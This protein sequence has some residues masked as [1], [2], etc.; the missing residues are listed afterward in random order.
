MKSIKLDVWKSCIKFTKSYASGFQKLKF[1]GSRKRQWTKRGW[2]SLFHTQEQILWFQQILI[3]RS[4][5][6]RCSM[7]KG[8]L[9]NF[10]KFT[11][12]HLCRAS[13]LIRRLWHRC[14]SVNFLNIF[15]RTPFVIEPLWW[16]LLK[17]CI[18]D[19]IDDGSNYL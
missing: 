2:R 11:G 12:K 1:C 3:Y 10:G 16:L 19:E 8:V 17:I 18:S 15:L 6:Q 7:K 4:S 13:F 5:H 14:F 9:R